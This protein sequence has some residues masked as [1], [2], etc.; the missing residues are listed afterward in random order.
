MFFLIC[1]DILI[2]ILFQNIILKELDMKTKAEEEAI[3]IANDARWVDPVAHRIMLYI[4]CKKYIDI[5]NEDA[6][7]RSTYYNPFI[8]RAEHDYNEAVAWHVLNNADIFAGY[9]EKGQTLA[10]IMEVINRMNVLAY[11]QR[12]ILD[13]AFFDGYNNNSMNISTDDESDYSSEGDNIF[14]DVASPLRGVD[15]MHSL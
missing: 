1:R 7:F 2:I 9:Q 4:Y 11:P 10:Y 8:L 14:T 12:I 3:N 15:F 13:S 6:E 5:L